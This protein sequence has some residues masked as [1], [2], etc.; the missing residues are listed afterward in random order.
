MITRCEAFIDSL[1]F[2]RFSPPVRDF[3]IGRKEFKPFEKTIYIPNMCDHA[4][5]VRASLARFGLNAE[6]MEESDDATLDYGKRF[7]SGK[8]CFPCI[9]TT[10][11]MIKKIRSSDFDDSHTVFLMP[12]ADGPCRFG[13]YCEYHRMVLDDLGYDHIPI[14]SPNSADGY[15]GFGL[16]NTD[17]RRVAWQAVVFVDCLIKM[18]HRTRPYETEVGAAEKLY[19]KYLSR[20]DR[21]VVKRE[22]LAQLADEAARAFAAL[23]TAG[24]PKPLVSVVGEIFLRNN[25]F[26]NNHLIEKLEKLGLEVSLATFSEWTM[27]TSLDYQRDS[28]RDRELRGFL[29]ATLQVFMQSRYENKL[30]SR[31]NRRFDIGHEYPVRKTLKLASRYLHLDYKGEAVLTIGKAVEMAREGASGIVNAMPFNCMPGT[32][33]SSLSKKVS[34]DLGDIPWLN[35]S[36]EGRR[37]SG[38]ETRLEAFAE[39]TRAFSRRRASRSPR[40]AL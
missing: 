36:Y 22:S 35:I 1:R 27:Y 40:A 11:D 20:L 10:G 26:S 30:I 34:E 39:Q 9:V 24:E 2:Y 15:E 21:A 31:F 18:L 23:S 5:A 8:E 38:E 13:L 14:L 3:N 28:L 16:E 32:V 19:L 25:R 29:A 4:Y 6:V 7:T 12:G 37:D 33:V 17:F